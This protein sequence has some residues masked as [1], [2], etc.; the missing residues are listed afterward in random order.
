M[1][2]SS[3]NNSGLKLG[4]DCFKFLRSINV[5]ILD[6]FNL[7][8]FIFSNIHFGERGAESLKAILVLQT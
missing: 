2:L 4:G 6:P 5:F 8:L 3:G 7:K 1:F